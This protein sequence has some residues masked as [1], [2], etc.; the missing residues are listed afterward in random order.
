MPKW[1]TAEELALTYVVGEER[2]LEYGRRGNLPMFCDQDGTMRF[3][4]LFVAKLFRTLPGH[5]VSFAVPSGPNLGVL[6]VSRLGDNPSVNPA[7]AAFP[8]GLRE[9][10]RRGLQ[11][12]VE[13]L[14]PPKAVGERA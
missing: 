5:A 4:E 7:S 3:D 10:H 14:T 9:T 12:D 6:G 2:L 13:T 8:R 11:H 1:K